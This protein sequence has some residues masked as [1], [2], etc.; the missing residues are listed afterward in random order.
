MYAFQYRKCPRRDSFWHL[1]RAMGAES[2]NTT[3]LRIAYVCRDSPHRKYPDNETSNHFS[4]GPCRAIAIQGRAHVLATSSSP[5][6]QHPQALASDLPAQQ[7]I[8]REFSHG[9]LRGK[10]RPDG[11]LKGTNRCMGRPTDS[12]AFM[13]MKSAFVA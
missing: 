10:R 6:A 12:R 7:G 2:S 11:D 4:S 3:L 9:L 1:S 13:N 5:C 8:L